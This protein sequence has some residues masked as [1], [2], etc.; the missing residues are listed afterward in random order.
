MNEVAV[1]AFP[2]PIDE[3]GSFEIGNEFLQFR[4]HAFP[5][6]YCA[7]ERLGHQEGFGVGC[8]SLIHGGGARHRT[9]A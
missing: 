9:F 8:L 3:P 7:A 6:R 4:R 2:A 5:F 1:T